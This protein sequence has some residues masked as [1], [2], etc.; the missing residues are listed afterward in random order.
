M[1][2]RALEAGRVGAAAVVLAGVVVA[3]E[4]GE[5]RSGYRTEGDAVFVDV[6]NGT[7]G[8]IRVKS[9]AVR[10]F[11]AG[12]T[13]L[14][15]QTRPCEAECDVAKGEAGTFGPIDGPP[16]WESV[17]VAEVAHEP[18]SSVERPAP[19]APSAPAARAAGRR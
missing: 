3:A 10:F 2:G 5:V 15:K 17:Q 1:R 19:R 11:D 7:D 13:P 9:V 16:D 4:A 6:E 12:G 14:G 8:A 18:I